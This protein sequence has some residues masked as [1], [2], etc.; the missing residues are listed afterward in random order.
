MRVDVDEHIAS[1]E[2]A[3]DITNKISMCRLKGS[4]GFLCKV[5][6][7]AYKIYTA[8]G[9]YEGS[10]GFPIEK[11]R[12]YVVKYTISGAVD[13]ARLCLNVFIVWEI[14]TEDIAKPLFVVNFSEGTALGET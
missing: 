1:A 13:S 14:S 10:L 9:V 6:E 5:V 3:C 12:P 8:E 2:H 7:G 11:S 4:P